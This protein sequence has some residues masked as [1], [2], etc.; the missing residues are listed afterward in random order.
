MEV[1]VVANWVVQTALMDYWM[2]DGWDIM[3]ENY[4]VELM[5]IGAVA[6]M[7]ESKASASAEMWAE[8]KVDNS[9]AL[10]VDEKDEFSV[11]MSVE[12]MASLMV[13]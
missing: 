3:K 8:S 5:A 1:L 13:A 12:Q 4:Q 9:A 10:M 6:S 7:A 2:V 11:I